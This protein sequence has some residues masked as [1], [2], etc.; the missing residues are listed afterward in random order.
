[1]TELV[2]LLS[3]L[4]CGVNNQGATGSLGG[5]LPCLFGVLRV[6]SEGSPLSSPSLLFTQKT[7]LW[8]SFTLPVFVLWLQ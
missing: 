5:Q 7:E 2:C 3:C 4:S 8:G 1:M 6:P